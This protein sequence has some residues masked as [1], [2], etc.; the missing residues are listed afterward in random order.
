VVNSLTP[1]LH[2]TRIFSLT[3]YLLKRGKIYKFGLLKIGLTKGGCINFPF[4]KSP[5]SL[6]LRTIIALKT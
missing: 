5:F 1:P 4:A 2:C 3:A 6:G